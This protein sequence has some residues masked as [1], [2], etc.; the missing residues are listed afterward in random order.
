[1][2]EADNSGEIHLAAAPDAEDRALSLNLATAAAP[3]D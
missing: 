2:I 1:L 3:S